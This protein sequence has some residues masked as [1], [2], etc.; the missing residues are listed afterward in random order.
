MRNLGV[1]LLGILIVKK[2][3]RN[4]VSLSAGA[5]RGTCRGRAPLLGIWKDIGRRA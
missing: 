5:V 4:G 1:H 2:G 3:P